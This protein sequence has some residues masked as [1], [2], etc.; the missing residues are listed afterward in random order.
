MFVYALQS[1]TS[2]WGSVSDRKNTWVLESVFAGGHS[3]SPII[4]Q[5][6]A[7]VLTLW[8]L[9]IQ[10]QAG[11]EAILAGVIDPDIQTRNVK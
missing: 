1:E 2:I 3:T 4:P 9:C 10:E 6:I 5:V 7:T 11:K 8:I